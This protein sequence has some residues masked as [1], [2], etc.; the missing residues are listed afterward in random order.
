MPLPDFD[1]FEN[2]AELENETQESETHS[3]THIKPSELVEMMNNDNIEIVLIDCR[4]DYEYNAGHIHRARSVN[5]PNEI[6]HYF[7]NIGEN[8]DICFENVAIVFYCEYSQN[9]GPTMAS[10][11]RRIDRSLNY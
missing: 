2:E 1:A 8:Q 6:D 10:I 11:F 9:R 7:T 4:F 5:W 3:I